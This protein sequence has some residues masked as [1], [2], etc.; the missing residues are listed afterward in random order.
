MTSARC[1]E[2]DITVSGHGVNGLTCAADSSVTAI[3]GYESVAGV[4]ITDYSLTPTVD[5]AAYKG[6]VQVKM[7]VP[8]DWLTE[9]GVIQAFLKQDT[10]RRPPL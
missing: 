4:K 7:P 1:E 8:A 2:H 3:A 6:E 5:N 10:G 9:G